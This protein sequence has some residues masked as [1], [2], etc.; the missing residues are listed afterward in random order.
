MHSLT[1]KI[2]LPISLDQAWEFFSDLANL[3][4]ITPPDMHFRIL[5]GTSSEGMYPGMIIRYRVSP[6]WGI[7]M[8][9]ATE[10][11]QVVPKKYFIDTQIAGPYRIWHHQHW[12]REV[13]GGV[14]MTDILHYSIPL[15]PLGRLLNTLLIGKRV[16]HIF[17]YREKILE[18]LFG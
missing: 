15:G 13:K 10:I 12:F 3:G 6:L 18:K 8:S 5:P 4:K 2:F 17:D 7:P 1:K 16:R 9:W 14:E 11:T